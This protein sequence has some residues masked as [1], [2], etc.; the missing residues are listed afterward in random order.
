MCCKYNSSY[1]SY[2][3]QIPILHYLNVDKNFPPV[4][5]IAPHQAQDAYLYSLVLL[6]FF[7]LNVLLLQLGWL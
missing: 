3:E 5:H 4:E 1:L 6:Y 2:T 7:P